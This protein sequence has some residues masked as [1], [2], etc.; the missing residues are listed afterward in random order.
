LPDFGLTGV[1]IFAQECQGAH[2]HARG[3]E[4]ALE[5]MLSLEGL[6]Q[7]VQLLAPSQSLYRS[8]L[9]AVTLHRQQQTTAYSLAVKENGTGTTDPVLAAKMGTGQIQLVAQKI[10]Q[11]AAGFNRALDCLTVH[12]E[13][14]GVLARGVCHPY[15]SH[16][17][18]MRLTL[19]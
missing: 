7:W 8:D 19:A 17:A 16:L 5:A 3:A 2:E 13:A 6:L 11:A 18:L 9:G 4:A 10:C 1:W 15:T 12:P 14:N